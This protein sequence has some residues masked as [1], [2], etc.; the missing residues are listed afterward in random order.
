MSHGNQHM[1]R[2]I[3][4][5]TP[6]IRKAVLE[7]TPKNMVLA[8]GTA[9]RGTFIVPR[10]T[11]F[12]FLSEPGRELEQS[13]VDKYF[14]ELFSSPKIERIPRDW[15]SRTYLPGSEC[16]NLFLTPSDRM[17]PGMGVHRLPLRGF[18]AVHPVHPYD[19]IRDPEKLALDIR[20]HAPEFKNV[21]ERGT[22]LT[23]LSAIGQNTGVVF[24]VACRTD[25]NKIKRTSLETLREASKE[26]ILRRKRGLHDVTGEGLSKELQERLLLREQRRKL[27]AEAAR[28]KKPMDVDV[29]RGKKRKSTEVSNVSN[30]SNVEDLMDRLSLGVEDTERQKSIIMGLVLDNRKKRRKL[31]R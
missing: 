16:P 31:S 1:R 26:R 18:L 24:V 15:V 28:G 8:H 13:V 10:G 21:V 14:Y 19:S 9:I 20:K 25:A 27:R 29:Q 3:N 30:V 6:K 11:S 22:P 17:W 23:M 4:T 7:M 12:V 2:V 5:T